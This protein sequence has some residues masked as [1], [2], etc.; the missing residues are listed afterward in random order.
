MNSTGNDIVALNAIDVTRTRQPRFYSKILAASEIAA[1]NEHKAAI[2][3]ENFLWLSWSSKESAYKYLQRNN[4]GL[5]FSPTRCIVSELE[6]PTEYPTS[7]EST[8]VL[9]GTGF[10]NQPIFKSIVTVGREILYSRSIVNSDFIFSVV[11]KDNN[12]DD[13]GWGVK[14]INDT[15]S[16]IQSAEVRSFLLRKLK[17]DLSSDDLQIVKND[18]G[19]PV[20]VN[21]EMDIP[22]SLAHHGHWVG[23]SC[24]I[25]AL[26]ELS[27]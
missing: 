13:T 3:L 23:Y 10:D 26:F 2:T 22:V 16:D 12:F 11:N 15:S 21:A 19:C 7:D 27:S 25:S 24:Q 1:C 6:I 20:L 9:Q 8:A 17:G 14:W 4:P 18:H 5:I